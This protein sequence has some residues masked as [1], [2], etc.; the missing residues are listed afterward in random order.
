MNN[1]FAYCPF[2][3]LTECKNDFNHRSLV[4]HNASNL[5]MQLAPLGNIYRQAN[6]IKHHF[7]ALIMPTARIHLT[8]SLA[9]CLYQPL[10]LDCI[11][12]PQTTDECKFLLVGQHWCL[13]VEESIGNH[14]LWFR[15]FFFRNALDV[16]FV[17]F[18][19]VCDMTG[20]WLYNCCFVGYCFQ[21]LLKTVCSI[22]V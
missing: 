18:W 21:D 2:K 1:K 7:Y 8:L 14:R 17:L 6:A 22:L 10:L 15:T 3:S 12:F 13:Y 9:T 4:T 16:L 19:M 5:A 11:Q 20:K